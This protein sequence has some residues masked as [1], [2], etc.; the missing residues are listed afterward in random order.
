MDTAGRKERFT[1]TVASG[2]ARPSAPGP[3]GKMA[4]YAYRDRSPGLN[5][6]ET[7]R[8]GG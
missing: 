2:R 4:R 3:M 8:T 6:H 1:R 5:P 7:I